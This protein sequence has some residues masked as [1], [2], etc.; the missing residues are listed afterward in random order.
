MGLCL[1]PTWL[2]GDAW[3]RDDSRVETL[4][5]GEFFIDAALLAER[6]GFEFIFKPD[7][8]LINTQALN[9]SVGFMGPDPIV[10]MSMM[11]ACTQRVGL[12]PTYSS[13]FYPPYLAARELQTLDHFSGGRA[14]VNLVT[15]LGGQENFGHL[16]K[17]SEHE[18][19]QDHYLRARSWLECVQRLHQSFPASALCLDRKEGIFAH[20]KAIRPLESNEWGVRGPL[21]VPSLRD[22]PLPV[23][24][25]GK[26]AASVDLAGR[27]AQGVFGMSA[28]MSLAITTRAAL[29]EAARHH[30]RDPHTLKYLPGLSITLS[31]REE[32]AVAL[33]KAM[34][35]ATGATSPPHVQH[36][37]IVGTP[38]QALEEIEHWAAAGAID[39]FVALPGGSWE[40]LELM[41]DEL[42]PALSKRGL[43]QYGTFGS[44]AC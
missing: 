15:S 28:T 23:M 25:A 29:K 34:T 1:S 35:P 30:Q 2:R 41:A 39:G 11:A 38:A 6:G 36:W 27:Y 7:A 24:H 20:T 14:A 21:S 44:S 32:R 22:R 13:T 3:R 5:S 16:R 33:H 17:T 31:R 12:V 43:I 9:R 26:S 8:L 10:L 42:L 19:N 18:P 37:T 40:T 4:L